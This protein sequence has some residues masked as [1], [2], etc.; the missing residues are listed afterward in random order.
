MVKL[1]NGEKKLI[2]IAKDH[3]K[4]WNYFFQGGTVKI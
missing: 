4:V 3:A 1:S 2:S